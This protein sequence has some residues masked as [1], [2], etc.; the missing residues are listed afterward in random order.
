MFTKLSL[1]K[2]QNIS[3]GKQRGKSSDQNR[4]LDSS[5]DSS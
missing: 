2:I 4:T 3:Q 5:K 1:N